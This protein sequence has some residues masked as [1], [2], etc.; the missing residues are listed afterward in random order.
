MPPAAVIMAAGAVSAFG[1]VMSGIQAQRAGQAQSRALQYQAQEEKVASAAQ[2]TGADTR[3]NALL[4]TARTSAAAGG[5]SQGGSAK[6]VNAGSF[7]QA[8]LN[9]AYLRYQGNLASSEA[10]YEAANAR[11]Q[12]KQALFGGI[13]GA[14]TSLLTSAYMAKGGIPQNQTT[15]SP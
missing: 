5:V 3:A 11:Y 8:R 15:G 4:A 2:I 13:I 7:T 14:G 6:V 1:Q 10:L 12:G 9:E